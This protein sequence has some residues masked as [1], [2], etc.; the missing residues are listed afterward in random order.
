MS[1]Q[2]ERYD[3]RLATE[4]DIAGI[5]KVFESGEFAGGIS[6]QYLR[7]EDPLKSLQNDGERAVVPVAVDKA[8]GE[9]IGVGACVIR[10]GYVNG[11]IKTVGYLTGL[12]LLPQYQK[13]IA[14]LP[15]AYE[16]L[17]QATKDEVNVY[18][19]TILSDNITAQKLLEKKRRN[20]P[21]YRYLGDYTVYCMRTGRRRGRLAV[22]CGDT[23]GL[24]EF[25]ARH[26]PKLDLSP[27]HR[28]LHGLSDGDFY[29]FRE[30]GEIKIACAVW[31]QQA[32]K[33]YLLKGYAGIYK[34]LSKLPT[35]WLGYPPFPKSNQLINYA[36]ITLLCADE[37]VDIATIRAFIEKVLEMS[38]VYDLM[39]FGL[40]EDNPYLPIVQKIKHVKY[41]SRLYEVLWHDAK[42]Q[43][44]KPIN[45]EVGLL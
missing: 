11:E 29:T 20:M 5:K 26:L 3:L 38:R 36:S 23:A 42:E 12:K 34:T 45:L 31:N 6:V 17:Y 21:A 16:F 1:F 22:A 2:S 4:K 8:A 27:V 32:Y 10:K 13:R 30:N 25:Y 7:G 40:F 39:L 9:V 18:Y 14:V 35:K 33:Q 41:Q 19:T 37:T 28:H 43:L 44:Q 15:H 24:D